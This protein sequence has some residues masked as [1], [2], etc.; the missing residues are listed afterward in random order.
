MKTKVVT[1]HAADV[2]PIRFGTDTILIRLGVMRTRSQQMLR[3][4]KDLEEQ[5][6]QHALRNSPH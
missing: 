6:R 4:M 3:E 1:P 5:F 2:R